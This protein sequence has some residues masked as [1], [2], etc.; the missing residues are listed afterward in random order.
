MPAL[1][2]L[3]GLPIQQAVGTSLVAVAVNSYAGFMGYAGTVAVSYPLM[4]VFAA[5][6]VAG[7]FVG[8]ALHSRLSVETMRK[9]LGL[10]L[11]AIATSI[12]W[13]RL[14]H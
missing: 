13:Q 8:S 3:W 10:F 9:A 12:L 14:T 7:T 6:A 11:V 5:T 1:I 2:I 4:G